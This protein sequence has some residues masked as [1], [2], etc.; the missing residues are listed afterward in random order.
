MALILQ[1]RWV[2]ARLTQTNSQVPMLVILIVR[3]WAEYGTSKPLGHPFC[4]IL[5]HNNK[6]VC[7]LFR[8]RTLDRQSDITKHTHFD[9]HF[10]PAQRL[11]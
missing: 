9:L 7:K 4:T 6:N 3:N 5:Y 1:R 10:C 8:G 2:I 11:L